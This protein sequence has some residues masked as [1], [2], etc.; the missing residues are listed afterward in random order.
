MKGVGEVREFAAKQNS[1]SDR[2]SGNIKRE[3]SAKEAAGA[4]QGMEEMSEVCREKG[5]KLYL[6][7]D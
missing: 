7:N 1:N 5:E 3:T 4:E 6:P 2:A